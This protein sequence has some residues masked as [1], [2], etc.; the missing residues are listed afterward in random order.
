MLLPK[1]RSQDEEEETKCQ[2]YQNVK[3]ECRK[4]AHSMRIDVQ[5]LSNLAAQRDET[6]PAV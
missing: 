5:N 4:S 2:I 6:K 1:L 3:F